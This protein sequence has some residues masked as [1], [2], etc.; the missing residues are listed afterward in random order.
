MLL[1]VM[2][3][4]LGI[5]L[6]E[7]KA[8]SG[9]VNAPAVERLGQFRPVSAAFAGIAKGSIS[10]TGTASRIIGNNSL[11]IRTSSSFSGLAL[12]AIGHR[13]SYGNLNP[14]SPESNLFEIQLSPYRYGHCYSENG[15]AYHCLRLFLSARL[16]SIL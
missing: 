4:G 8:L 6:F 11:F 9:F 1:E 10:T 16:L 12:S 14:F 15:S 7:L 2:P 3:L 5:L 13:C